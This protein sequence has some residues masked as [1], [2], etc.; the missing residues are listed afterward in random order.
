MGKGLPEN[1][2]G[3][4]DLLKFLMIEAATCPF[5]QSNPIFFA[6]ADARPDRYWWR[7]THLLGMK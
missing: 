3:L 2:G 4:M 5:F 6:T 1:S 7:P